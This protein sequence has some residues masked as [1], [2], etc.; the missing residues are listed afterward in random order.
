MN[1]ISDMDTRKAQSTKR[2]TLHNVS[3]L[4]GNAPICRLLLAKMA[5]ELKAAEI[6]VG[7]AAEARADRA[8]AAEA[9]LLT[10]TLAALMEAAFDA[11]EVR[12]SETA[13][14]RCASAG[15]ASGASGGSK[16]EGEEEEEWEEEE[17]EEEDDEED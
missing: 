1:V 6:G 14:R 17:E 3:Y 8:A 12:T 2:D 10:K 9:K 13:K 15:A 4:R 5:A 16:G 7:H 11:A